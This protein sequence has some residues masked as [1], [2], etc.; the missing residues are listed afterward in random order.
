M[1]CARACLAFFEIE[2]YWQL[3][4]EQIGGDFRY[5]QQVGTRGSM[6]EGILC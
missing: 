4:A 2:F 1:K 6:S 3:D 5:N